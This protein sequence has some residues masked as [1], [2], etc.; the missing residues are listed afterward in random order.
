MAVTNGVS[1]L[2]NNVR[3]TLRSADVSFPSA[4]FGISGNLAS[5][6]HPLKA[7]T[8]ARKP[9]A[10]ARALAQAAGFKFSAFIALIWDF[11]IYT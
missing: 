3:T 6:H 2:A 1:R 11:A 5:N 8:D 10:R 9:N 7:L 4:S